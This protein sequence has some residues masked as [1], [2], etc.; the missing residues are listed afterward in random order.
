MPDSTKNQIGGWAGDR[1]R[2]EML[3]Y[4]KGSTAEN[5]QIVN[6][7]LLTEHDPADV[8]QFRRS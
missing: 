2:S 3:Q 4:A 6:A 1:N 5:L 8:I 7:Y